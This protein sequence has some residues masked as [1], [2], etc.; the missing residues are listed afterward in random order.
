MTAV[1]STGDLEN[2]FDAQINLI[3]SFFLSIE[4]QGL[5]R[6]N[7]SLVPVHLLWSSYDRIWFSGPNKQEILILILKHLLTLQ[8][9][10][11]SIGDLEDHFSG[12]LDKPHIFL[13]S[14]YKNTRSIQAKPQFGGTFADLA[15]HS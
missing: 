7:H 13:L 15:D 14:Q 2:Q 4:I 12:C 3:S 6:Q 11:K 10:V 8:T 1:N 9:T 5:S